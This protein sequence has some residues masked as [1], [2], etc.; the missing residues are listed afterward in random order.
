MGVLKALVAVVVQEYFIER[1]MIVPGS[2]L[3][4]QA[5]V[6]AVARK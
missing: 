4:L 1:S 5:V 3:L 6:V 2:C